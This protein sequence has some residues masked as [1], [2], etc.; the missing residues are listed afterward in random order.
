MSH[1]SIASPWEEVKPT[2]ATLSHPIP[3]CHGISHKPT[4]ATLS[5]PIP[6]CHGIS[7]NPS[8]LKTPTQLC[9]CLAM[10]LCICVHVC[11]QG[12]DFWGTWSW[13]ISG[14]Q[15]K[16]DYVLRPRMDARTRS[17]QVCGLSPHPQGRDDLALR[18]GNEWPRVPRCVLLKHTHWL[19]YVSEMGS[20]VA[21]GAAF[22]RQTCCFHQ[23]SL[24]CSAL[25]RYIAYVW[26]KMGHKF[27]LMTTHMW[28][29]MS[30][31]I[32]N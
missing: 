21:Y 28:G 3:L 25:C 24:W 2:Q 13:S 11:G 19:D 16:T 1:V 9:V 29:K 7:H 12:A 4:E 26:R 30:S 31:V 5:H 6:L 20:R 15:F 27:N 8:T 23:G 22:T 17:R 32:C 18:M 10:W 14:N